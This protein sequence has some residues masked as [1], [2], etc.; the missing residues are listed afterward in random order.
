MVIA[1]R[2]E[3]AVTSARINWRG[4]ARRSPGLSGEGAVKMRQATQETTG[5]GS[6][7]Q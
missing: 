3:L 4:H 7:A 1:G 5:L 6:G 2:P